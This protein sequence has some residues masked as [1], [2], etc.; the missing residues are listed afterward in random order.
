MVTRRTGI[1]KGHFAHGVRIAGFRNDGVPTCEA[2]Q[3][4]AIW[5]GVWAREGPAPI[6][7]PPSPGDPAPDYR[8]EG[9]LPPV[10]KWG[11]ALPRGSI[12]AGILLL[13]DIGVGIY[14]GHRVAG[15]KGAAR[16]GRYR[17]WGGFLGAVLIPA[18]TILPVIFW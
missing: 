18:A 1:W 15:W 10:E 6:W 3:A 14:W 9:D 8:R 16:P 4:I 7:Q 5:D 13:V 17:R 2:V 12:V 11:L